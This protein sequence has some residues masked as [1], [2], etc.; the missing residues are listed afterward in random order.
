VQ[1]EADDFIDEMIY[2]DDQNVEFSDIFDKAARK[3]C[4][5][6][7]YRRKIEMKKMENIPI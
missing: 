2:L 4:Y 5:N 3:E 6:F 7:P 1:E